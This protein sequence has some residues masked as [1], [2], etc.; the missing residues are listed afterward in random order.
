MA[1]LCHRPP[2][3]VCTTFD[4]SHAC[5][6]ALYISYTIRKEPPIPRIAQPECSTVS[7]WSGA[8][9]VAGAA[10]CVHLAAPSG[11]RCIRSCARPHLSPAHT[12][13]VRY[14]VFVVCFWVENVALQCTLVTGR[15]IGWPPTRTVL[16]GLMTCGRVVCQ[17]FVPVGVR[18]HVC[19]PL[20]CGI[21]TT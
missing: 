14:G 15:R 6:H 9:L 19:C 10:R 8:V 17:L 16:H 3:V 21:C 12:V 4:S 18:V 2:H 20:S 13:C 1:G 11:C 7:C 5:T